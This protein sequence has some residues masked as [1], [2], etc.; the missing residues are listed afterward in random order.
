[1]QR[2]YR[3]I[4]LVM[5]VPL[6]AGCWSFHYSKVGI[7]RFDGKA[8]ARWIEPD[9]FTYEP[10]TSDPLRFVCPNG[11]KIQPGP[12]YTDGGSIPRPMWIFRNYSP[13][14]YVPAYLI[15]D[16][17]FHARQCQLPGSDRYTFDDST[18]ILSECI[19][20]LME[21]NPRVGVDKFTMY[22]IYLAVRSNVAKDAW[23]SG[24]CSMPPSPMQITRA[25]EIAAATQNAFVQ[26]FDFRGG[27]GPQ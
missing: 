23:D 6:L 25:N 26:V 24:R 18:L 11:D 14:G 16:W 5:G 9:K 17:L 22:T 8:T 4:G 13:W 10:D 2:L 3:L 20:T 12:M 15:H 19:K 21:T 7:G 27:Q 1:M